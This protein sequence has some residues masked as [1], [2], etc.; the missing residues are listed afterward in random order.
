MSEKNTESAILREY[1]GDTAYIATPE[2]IMKVL[3]VVST[4]FLIQFLLT[5]L[6]LSSKVGI[7]LDIRSKF[8]ADSR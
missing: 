4:M 5:V 6:A 1:Y 2:G 7:R 3:A 8:R